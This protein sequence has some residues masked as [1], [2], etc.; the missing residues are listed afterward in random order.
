[1]KSSQLR[2]EERAAMRLKEVV[3]FFSYAAL[4]RWLLLPHRV[5]YG[6]PS[7]LAIV[8]CIFHSVQPIAQENCRR[9]TLLLQDPMVPL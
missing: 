7:I 8:S 9:S 2:L 6:M 3:K 1:M 4:W 5:L